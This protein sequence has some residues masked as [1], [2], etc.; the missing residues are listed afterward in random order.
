MEIQQIKQILSELSS[1]DSEYLSIAIEEIEQLK[2]TLIE[3]EFDQRKTRLQVDKYELLDD[4][5]KNGFKLFHNILPLIE[6]FT[7][8]A[9]LVFA[10]IM[11][12]PAAIIASGMAII[13]LT[14]DAI[15]TINS[16]YL[17][18][19]DE[20]KNIFKRI[21]KSIK[22]MMMSK[23]NIRRRL[24]G[25]IIENQNNENDIKKIKD[26][27]KRKEVRVEELKDEMSYIEGSLIGINKVIEKN[28]ID[29]LDNDH[30]IVEF[31]SHKKLQRK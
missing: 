19:S 18:L 11:L 24:V 21:S 12:T 26:K 29:E 22:M 16:S 3:K 6:I 28:I 4:M 8:L 20:E 5:K 25:S 2:K 9:L 17:L 13:A 23:K 14:T 30:E 15:Q 27:I 31:V 10:G 1:E 7:D